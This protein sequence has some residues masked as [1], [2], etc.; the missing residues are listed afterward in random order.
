MVTVFLF[1]V[2]SLLRRLWEGRVVW[3]NLGLSSFPVV[4]DKAGIFAEV[5]D[6]APKIGRNRP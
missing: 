3:S 2:S 5:E 4:E 1:L 6:Q